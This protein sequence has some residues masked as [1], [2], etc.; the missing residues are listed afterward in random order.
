MN[1]IAT[2]LRQ[3]GCVLLLC[4]PLLVQA[5]S[6]GCTD[7][8]A[9]NYDPWA[10]FDDGSCEDETHLYIPNAEAT[11]GLP[12]FTWC[13]PLPDCSNPSF[14]CPI[15][16]GFIPTDPDCLE[17]ILALAPSCSESW[18]STCLDLYAACF[19]GVPGCTDPMACNFDPAATFENNTC[20][21]PGAPCDDADPCTVDD[22][23]NLACECEG[24]PGD[25]DGDGLCGEQDCNDAE[26]GLPDFLGDC[27]STVAGC[28]DAGAL[29]FRDAVAEI[30]ACVNESPC[31]TWQIEDDWSFGLQGWLAEDNWATSDPELVFFDDRSLVILGKDN[32]VADQTWAEITAP[33]AMDMQ[34]TFAYHTLD[35]NPTYDPPFVE[36]NGQPSGILDYLLTTFPPGFVVSQADSWLHGQ[37]MIPGPGIA[38]DPFLFPPDQLLPQ[39]LLQ[40]DEDVWDFPYQVPL[41]LTLDSGDVV[42]FGVETTDG[43][44]GRG[45]AVFTAFSHVH[46]CA[47]CK[48]PDAC[49][50]DV[51]ATTEDGSCDYSCYGCLEELACNFNPDATVIDSCD[52]TCYGCMEL[53]ACNFFPDATRP[54]TCDYSCYGCMDPL[55]CNYHP[56]YTR[57]DGSC[58]YCSCSNPPGIAAASA[59]P[60]G[61]EPFAATLLTTGGSLFYCPL[62]ELE[63]AL[64]D[65][66]WSPSIRID[67]GGDHVLALRADSVLF[68][69]GNNADGQL[70][71]PADVDKIGAFSAGGFHSVVIDD[72]GELAGWGSNAAGQLDFPV[73]Q[74]IGGVEAGALHTVAWDADG[75]LLFA[76]GDNTLGQCDVPAGVQVIKMAS[77]FHNVALTVD[78]TVVCWGSNS[79]GQLDV[80]PISLPVVDV[81][82]SLHTSMALLSDSTVVVWGRL[83]LMGDLPAVWDIDGNPLRDQLAML[84]L[85]GRGHYLSDR[86]YIAFQGPSPGVHAQSRPRCTEWC[87][88]IDEDG[89]CDV[90]DPCIGELTEECGCLCIHDINENGVCDELEIQGCMDPRALNFNPR[91]TLDDDCDVFALV[92]CQSPIACN[93]EPLATHP[94]LCEFEEC[95][96]CDDSFACN[97]DPA[98]L[99]NNGACEYSSC[100]GCRDPLACNFNPMVPIGDSCAYCSCHVTTPFLDTW[101]PHH[102][103]VN[104][105]GEATYGGSNFLSQASL[106][107]AVNAS[108]LAGTT[109]QGVSKGAASLSGALLLMLDGSIQA[110]SP[111]G[112]DYFEEE[113]QA[114]EIEMETDLGG[115]DLHLALLN[116]NIYAPEGNDFTDVAMAAASYMALRSDSTVAVW[117]SIT[118]I[119]SSF[120]NGYN[121]E[122]SGNADVPVEV[123]G[124]SQSGVTHIGMSG[125]WTY[126]VLLSDGTTEGYSPSS[127]VI[128]EPDDLDGDLVA[129]DCSQIYCLY[130]TSTGELRGV[131]GLNGSLNYHGPWEHGV[132]PEIQ[133][134]GSIVDFDSDAISAVLY[135]DGSIGVWLALAWENDVYPVTIL[136]ASEVGDVVDVHGGYALHLIGAD[137]VIRMLQIHE[138]FDELTEED[139]AEAFDGVTS[140]SF[141]DSMRVAPTHDCGQGC[142]DSDGDGLCDGADDCIGERD[143]LGIC[144]G[145]CLMDANLDGICDLLDRPGCT[146]IEACTYLEEATWDDGSCV[147]SMIPTEAVFDA[148]SNNCPSDLD[149]NGSV[150]TADLLVL[151]T[152]FGE[153]CEDD[154]SPP[155]DPCFDEVPF[156]CGAPYSF[157][158]H[159]YSTVLIDTV[160]WFQENLRAPLFSNGQPLTVADSEDAWGATDGAVASPPEWDEALIDTYGLLYNVAAV[161]DPR[162]L[163]PWGWHIGTDA[164]W[165]ASEMYVGMSETEAVSMGSRGEDENI[166][167][168]FKANS[169]LWSFSG[170]GSNLSGFTALPAGRVDHLG[171]NQ[172]EGGS[173]WFW[174]PSGTVEGLAIRVLLSG[175]DGVFRDFDNANQGMS[176]RCVKD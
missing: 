60:D 114:T 136:D 45:S 35:L 163:C 89:V 42:R 131:G 79:F 82:A 9:C 5:Q 105:K 43:A 3:A 145:D 86:G 94:G 119:L 128:E 23:F 75:D 22:S 40:P 80:P 61:E 8:G 112:F 175:N 138:V 153:V 106:D 172:S 44:F 58:E 12:V 165:M 115:I 33:V 157:R 69:S 95:G 2:V 113:L 41:T 166:A 18:T 107:N 81:A 68:G 48:D 149:G 70:N 20:L 49:N 46:F 91:A 152:A 83:P 120:R 39:S 148:L 16:S 159:D 102:L 92:G 59:F 74:N 88:D 76:V 21:F 137:G 104:S 63:P 127:G 6:V 28:D 108:A 169:L 162:G 51:N 27:P 24:Q 19:L 38:P 31:N 167:S 151:L 154:A 155:F 171:N 123:W 130:Q 34:F 144:G 173:A 73:T 1:Q 53:D 78:S 146:Y 62:L 32:Q 103:L 141:P 66:E 67:G 54:D 85:N 14:G 147:F 118:S 17:Q 52:Y 11:L 121:E 47:G 57:D 7:P 36:V 117:G 135:E 161:T 71:V 29:N 170:G 122:L 111:S 99:W 124:Q 25:G 168:R 143:A 132:P 55:G 156:D 30:T 142:P 72:E 15:P 37:D 4:A 174:A 65:G 116:E 97:Y 139:T 140:L 96:G 126:H 98:A 84:D 134:H 56:D 129:M 125:V 158:G 150:A 176:V 90:E 164:D 100:V 101:M 160:C 10:T 64:L 50:F 77:A 93:Y 109:W 13:G 87:L 110:K 26:P 133:A